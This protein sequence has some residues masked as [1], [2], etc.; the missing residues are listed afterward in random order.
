MVLLVYIRRL[1][2]QTVYI[3]LPWVIALFVPYRLRNCSAMAT[4][5]LPECRSNVYSLDRESVDA[6]RQGQ[7]KWQIYTRSS[8]RHCLHH[9][10]RIVNS[11]IQRSVINR[12]SVTQLY[13][14]MFQLNQWNI[15]PRGDVLP[16]R[17]KVH[18]N[19][20]FISSLNYKEII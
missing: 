6:I 12:S 7:P 19:N 3:Y 8:E 18:S 13:S 17:S 4:N 20:Y 5:K 16:R 1:L 10:I 14:W 15:Q 2:Q 11:D 9:V